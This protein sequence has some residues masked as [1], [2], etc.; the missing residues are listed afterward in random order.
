MEMRA[1]MVLESTTLDYRPL[2]AVLCPAVVSLLV[3][4]SGRRPNVR[5]SF[6]LIGSVALFA[7]VSSMTGSVLESGAIHL[8]LLG[9]F[10]GVDLAFKV[11]ACSLVFAI[12]S[13]SLWIVVSVYSI[14][15]MR[16]LEEH[17]Q[18]RYYFSFAVAIVG[19]IGIAFSANLVTMFV[20]YEILTVSTYALVAHDETP[21]AISGGHKYLVYLLTGGVFFLAGIVL[22]YALVGSTDFEPGG[23]LEPALGSTSRVTLWILFFCFMLGFMKAAWMPVHS[24]LPTAMVA[25]TPVSALLHAVA[26]V[27][28]GVFGIIKIV[29]YLYGTNLMAELGLGVML[30][31]VAAVTII[32]ANLCAIGQGNLKRL[33]A[34]STINQLSLIILGA[35]MLTPMSAT[36]ALIHIPFH[37]FMKIT[38]FLCAGTLMAVANKREISEMAGIGREM[39]VTMIAF[40]IAA[41]GMCGAPPL[42]GFISKWYLSLG[43]IES[44]QL[45]FLLV[46]LIG[47]LLDVVYF[48]PVIKTAFFERVPEI[49]TLGRDMEEKVAFFS[50]GVRIKETERPLYSFM[51]IPLAVTAGLSI[52]FCLRPQTLHVYDLVQMAVNDIF[53]G[54]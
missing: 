3:L 24:W 51:I 28:A 31:S 38:L 25:P 4:A 1:V 53:G 54:K 49:E 29:F 52:L 50:E 48:F 22:T 44:G 46:I 43:A 37:G 40:T 34:Y 39:P 10:P 41:L 47:S 16:A 17:A 18:T 21:E 30:A 13:S 27:K 45:G 2:I 14:G 42:A 9:L 35:A 15:Y 20:F 8:T 26:V 12:T 7:V 33:L 5:E 6:T 11:D 19:A 23:I 36:G 32:V